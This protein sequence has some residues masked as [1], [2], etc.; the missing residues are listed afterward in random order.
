MR[1]RGDKKAKVSPYVPGWIHDAVDE[2]ARYRDHSLRIIPRE[3]EAAHALVMTAF[4]DTHT[5]NQLSPY[6]WRTYQ[7]NDT[8]WPGHDSYEDIQA[9][10]GFH[11]LSVQRIHMRFS[12]LEIKDLLE[13]K[14]A[15]S[16]PI[17]HTVCALLVLA[18]KQERVVKLA[19]RI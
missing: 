9:L 6:F 7:R 11:G 2:V 18:L 14:A 17:A 3:G 8:I 15:L 10:I 13:L 4:H 19:A 1:G 16:I 12:K 5:I